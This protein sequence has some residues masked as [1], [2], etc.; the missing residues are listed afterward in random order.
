MNVRWRNVS[1]EKLSNNEVS[2]IDTLT[3]KI[4]NQ[5]GN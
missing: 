3:D 5:V 2:A 4:G 1:D